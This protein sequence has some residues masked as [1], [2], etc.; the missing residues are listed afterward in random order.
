[1]I[2]LSGIG[3]NIGASIS[4][5]LSAKTIGDLQKTVN[6]PSASAQDKWSAFMEL[7]HRSMKAD[8]AKRKA[9]EEGDEDDLE[10]LLQKLLSGEI[11][12][13]E[14]KKLAAKLGV[15][16]SALEALKGESKAS[17]GDIK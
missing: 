8:A 16:P 10:K 11:T 14:L 17:P 2:E 15:D 6:D 3:S 5:D 9:E 4:P 13:A 1:M 7:F 12:P